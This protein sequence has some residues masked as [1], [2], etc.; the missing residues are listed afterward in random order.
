M[1]KPPRSNLPAGALPWG[2][3]IESAYADIDANMTRLER[4]VEVREIAAGVDL[5]SGN[6]N[7]LYRRQPKLFTP[8]T[9]IVLNAPAD[10]SVSYSWYD[11]SFTSYRQQTVLVSGNIY[12]YGLSGNPVTAIS[13]T[14][15]GNSLYYFA[16]FGPIGDA[17]TSTTTFSFNGLMTFGVGTYNLSCTLSSGTILPFGPLGATTATYDVNMAVLPE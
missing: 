2:R 1:I 13:V 16:Q 5:L 11:W 4:D 8:K 7:S 6:I 17:A 12:A 9:G 3:E 10:S 14:A 15:T